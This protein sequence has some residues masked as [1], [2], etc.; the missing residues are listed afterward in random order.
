MNR[1]EAIKFYSIDPNLYNL[2]NSGEKTLEDLYRVKSYDYCKEEYIKIG[3][4]RSLCHGDDWDKDN[5][6]TAKTAQEKFIRLI[7]QHQNTRQ[8]KDNRVYHKLLRYIFREIY[9]LVTPASKISITDH[10]LNQ[11]CNWY[12]ESLKP[13]CDDKI[14]GYDLHI[15]E[16]LDQALEKLFFCRT[17]GEDL[18]KY[19]RQEFFVHKY[20]KA[21]YDKRGHECITA[22]K[23]S[24]SLN[25]WRS[26]LFP[27][28]EKPIYNILQDKSKL[29]L[30][31][32]IV[33][34]FGTVY[35]YPRNDVD[36]VNSRYWEIR[37]PDKDIMLLQLQYMK[38][39]YQ[40]EKNP[41]YILQINTNYAFNY[42]IDQVDLND[43][44]LYLELD[45]IL[46]EIDN[47]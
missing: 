40:I 38:N 34:E 21:Y 23:E 44:D 5:W 35:I 24:L 36:Y 10:Q 31:P 17:A 27:L 43:I 25:Y 22:V 13:N 20:E 30:E 15:N 6:F 32:I 26:G 37:K 4:I 7:Y 18:T 46:K 14:K 2:I 11:Y 3:V 8:I 45:V 47:G 33:S 39:K 16:Y 41:I 9:T 28:V 42:R 1:L 29:S 19:F 12:L